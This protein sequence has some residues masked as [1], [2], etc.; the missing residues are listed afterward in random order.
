MRVAHINQDY[1]PHVG[2]VAILMKDLCE[3]LAS[4]GFE[5]IVYTL[6]R[7][8]GL[9]QQEWVHGILVKRYEPVFGDPAYLPPFSFLMDL[10]R[11]NVNILHV[12]NI[13]TLPATFV[14]LVKKQDQKLVLQPHYHRFGQTR[15]RNILFSFYK[16]VASSTVFKRA[17]VVIV[18]SGYEEKIVKEDLVCRDNIILVPEGLAV[19]ELKSIQWQPEYPERILYV[20]GLRRYKNV[21]SLL[22]AFKV[23]IDD[24]RGELKLIIIGD[25]PEKKR[26]VR[27]AF[28]LGINDSIEWKQGL[29]RP[30]LLSEYAKA[31]VFVSLSF[32]ESFSR[33]AH[34]ALIIG[35][36]M[37]V[38]NVGAMAGYVNSGLAIGTKSIDPEEVATAISTTRKSRYKSVDNLK[39][40]FQNMD[41]YVDQVAK[42]YWQV[43]EER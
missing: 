25:G 27:L 13:H 9:P 11:E 31:R 34:E 41:D 29:S 24:E 18:N 42:I 1:F 43:N 36:P 5:I 10:K 40:P 21:D 22:R 30:Q 39:L 8:R 15:V 16:A 3:R 26:L 28:E 12:H 14:S 35:V 37:V 4:R 33:V 19:K 20:G 6:D 23:L 32:L 17:D 38:F 2:G 7:D